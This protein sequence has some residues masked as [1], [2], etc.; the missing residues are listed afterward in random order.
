MAKN[1]IIDLAPKVE[2][3]TDEQLKAIQELVAQINQAQMSVGQLE[4]QKAGVIAAIG[5]LQMKM[6]TMQ[7]ELEEEYGKVSISIQDGSI[8]GEDESDTKD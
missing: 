6:N 7:K 5:D 8:K 1:E 4:T 2:K 3:I